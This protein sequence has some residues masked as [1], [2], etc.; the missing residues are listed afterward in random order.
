VRQRTTAGDSARW[1][2]WRDPRAARLVTHVFGGLKNIAWRMLESFRYAN[3]PREALA[4][5]GATGLWSLRSSPHDFSR[6]REGLARRAQRHSV[7]IAPDYSSFPRPLSPGQ[8]PIS[9]SCDAGRRLF[10][11]P[12]V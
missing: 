3:L 8:P 4:E 7:A 12:A 11:G 9:Q 10:A 6:R 5:S 2:R 1:A